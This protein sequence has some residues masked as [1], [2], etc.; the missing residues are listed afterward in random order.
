MTK[1]VFYSF[2]DDD[3]IGVNDIP[4]N[5]I[6]QVISSA[7]HNSEVVYFTLLDKS[8]LTAATKISD[9][10]ADNSLFHILGTNEEY[11]YD[12]PNNTMTIVI[13]P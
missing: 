11:E 8:G 3:S 13:K 4:L 1:K 12:E 7:L 9:I 6:S 2:E 5:A 10:F